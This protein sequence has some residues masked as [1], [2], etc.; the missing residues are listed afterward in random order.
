MTDLFR[1][2]AREIRKSFGGVEV[3]RGV[4][5]DATGGDVLALLGENGAGKSTLVKILAGDYEA[6]SGTIEIAGESHRTLDPAAARRRGIRM[7]FQEL[8]A[9]PDLTVAENVMLGQWPARYGI[10]NWRALR[11]AA[12]RILAE[13]GVPLDLDAPVASLRVAER[14][15]VEIARA[16]VG[17][18]SR[19]SG[20]S[21]LPMAFPTIAVTRS[22]RW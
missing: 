12:R 20:R 13:L 4:D 17:S 10:V 1:L 7:I 21:T 11:S 3:L 9:A 15:V 5:L 22:S 6:D 19:G 16:L 18:V 8:A 2:K 14:Q